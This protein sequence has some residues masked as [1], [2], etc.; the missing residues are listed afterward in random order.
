MKHII[1][2]SLVC[3]VAMLS[4]CYMLVFI[5]DVAIEI[6]QSISS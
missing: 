3:F 4:L 1:G 2:T 5:E 6:R